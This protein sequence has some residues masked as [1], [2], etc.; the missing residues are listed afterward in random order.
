VL[1]PTTLIL[2]GAIAFAQEAKQEQ[3]QEE[4]RPEMRVNMLNVCTPSEA[5]QHEIKA[6]LDR[7]PKRAAFTPDFEVSRGRTTMENASAARYLR[8]RRELDAKTG[9]STAQYSIST[10]AEKTTET[11]AM[12]LANP[13]DLL[14]VVLEDRVTADA[15][16]T[17]LL[18]V[19]TPVNRISL[20]R[21]GKSSLVLARCE[22]V[23]QKAYET[24]FSQ[25]SQIAASY[26]KSLGLRGTFRSDL[27]WLGAKSKADEA[28]KAQKP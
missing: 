18:Q 25:A 20:E 7:I 9:F 4:K 1:K 13:K 10:D 19:D 3:K 17:S 22:N 26:R 2:L 23:D 28:K 12:K 8:L 6:A 27:M 11:L 5:E 14:Q 16:A 15:P 21:F 24:L